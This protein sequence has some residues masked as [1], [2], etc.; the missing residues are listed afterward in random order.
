[1][2]IQKSFLDI[3]NNYFGYPE[4]RINVNSACHIQ[5]RTTKLVNGIADLKYD[6]RLKRLGLVRLENRRLTSDLIE[7]RAI[8][9]R[10]FAGGGAPG[11][12]DRRRRRAD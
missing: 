7:T 2:D 10:H 8:S 11:V 5:R 1:L 9:R 12:C 4:K 3:Q 6:D